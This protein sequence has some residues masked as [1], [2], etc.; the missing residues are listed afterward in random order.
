MSDILET[1]SSKNERIKN[2]I[3]KF[4]TFEP[5]IKFQPWTK[6]PEIDAVSASTV[7]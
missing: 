6:T 7:R 3:K 5:Q 2:K 1:G 4:N